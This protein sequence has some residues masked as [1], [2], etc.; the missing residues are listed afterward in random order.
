V[1]GRP[2]APRPFA[3]QELTTRVVRH[4]AA[5]DGPTPPLDEVARA[6]DVSPKLLAALPAVRALLQPEGLEAFLDWTLRDWLSYHYLFVH[7]GYRYGLPELQPTWR[8][9]TV[10]KNPLDCWVHQ[11]IIH[12][13]RPDVL[14]E[15]GVAFGG[16]ALFYGDLMELAGHGEVLAVD[17]SIERARDVSHPRVT[18][19]EGSSVD[20]AMV[21]SIAERCRGKR[22]MVVADSNHAGPHVLAELRAYADLVGVGMYFVVEDTLADV[23]D[24]MPVPIDGPLPAVDQFLKERPDFERDARVAERYLLSQSPYGYLRRAR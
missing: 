2:G 7:Q 24:L 9:R 16:S 12:S 5:L 15:L 20:L 13:T 23:L 18:L 11:E 6:L 1:N 21:E 19:L 10:L 14:V 4:L 22:V 3:S 8:G 17:I